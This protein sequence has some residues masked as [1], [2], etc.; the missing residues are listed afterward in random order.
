MLEVETLGP[1]VDLAPGAEATH[2]EDWEVW[3]GIPL[4]FGDEAGI[5]AR[6]LPLVERGRPRG[7][8]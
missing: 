4:T 2:R 6:L 8:R 5:R 3:T 1:L 7:N